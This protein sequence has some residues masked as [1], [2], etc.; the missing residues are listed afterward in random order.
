LILETGQLTYIGW[1]TGVRVPVWA[2]AFMFVTVC[3]V[4]AAC[5]SSD[6]VDT[7]CCFLEGKADH[8]PYSSAEVKNTWICTPFL[9]YV[10]IT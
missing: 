9:Q 10:I 1:K 6:P 2:D 4:S 3:V 5:A 8:E 7:W